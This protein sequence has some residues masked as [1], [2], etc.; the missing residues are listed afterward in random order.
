MNALVIVDPQ[1]DFINGS[2]AVPGAE[3]VLNRHLA[4]EFKRKNLPI[5]IERE[6]YSK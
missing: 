1:N 3:K 6:K 2:L 5:I 4:S